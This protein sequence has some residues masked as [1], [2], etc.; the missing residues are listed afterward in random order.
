MFICY[1]YFFSFMYLFYKV[2]RSLI[3]E[4]IK[5]NKEGREMEWSM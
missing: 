5:L 4:C 2:I 1:L 3:C